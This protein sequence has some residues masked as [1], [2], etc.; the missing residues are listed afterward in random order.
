MRANHVGVG[1]QA[2]IT[3][4]VC[5]LVGPLGVEARRDPAHGECTIWVN[6]VQMVV[7]IECAAVLATGLFI[8]AVLAFPG[9]W[10][11]KLVGVIVGL[12]GVGLLNLLRIVI[13]AAVAQHL[14][15]WFGLSHDV[16]MQGFLLIMVTPLW[17]GWL[18]WV[19]RASGKPGRPQ[20]ADQ[21]APKDSND[22][23]VPR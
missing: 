12:V 17:L 15:E 5:R 16:L 20:V 21:V 1:Y 11:T 6:N 23:S 22:A 3:G 9:G 4:T 7:T 18:A 8:S 13:L 19:L 2:A 14:P 10:Q